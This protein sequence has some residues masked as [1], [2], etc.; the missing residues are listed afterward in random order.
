MKAQRATARAQPMNPTPRHTI[1]CHARA[2]AQVDRSEPIAA[3]RRSVLRLGQQLSDKD[4][5]EAMAHDQARKK[6]RGTA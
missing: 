6:P 3:M 1:D 2:R 5:D 4:I